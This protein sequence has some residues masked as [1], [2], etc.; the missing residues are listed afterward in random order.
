MKKFVLLFSLMLCQYV[1]SQDQRRMQRQIDSL[2][3]IR[4]EYAKKIVQINILI[5]EIED[6]KTINEIEQYKIL[7]YRVPAQSAIKI[8]DKESPAGKILFEPPKGEVITLVDFNDITDYWL[9]SYND[10]VGYVNDVFLH[11]SSAITN[12]KKYLF[13]KRAQEAEENKRKAAEL[14]KIEE[15][16]QAEARTKDE[17]KR[18]SVTIRLIEDAKR[19]AEED[20][21]KEEQR[22]AFLMKKYGSTTGENI[23][24]G[25]VWIGMKDAMAKESW[26]DPEVINRTVGYWGVR[27][28]WVYPD[29]N[30][31][32]FENGA[33][34]LW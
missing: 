26:G 2:K 1:H 29:E 10:E 6:K 22:K 19:I 17:Q 27:E 31:L 3:L 8:R 14:T 20:K 12:F 4:T 15:Q 32:Y 23:F 25:R 34:T 9:V 30:Y 33:L 16:N 24:A 5:K 11:K 28:Q 21:K 18:D 13:A 7:K